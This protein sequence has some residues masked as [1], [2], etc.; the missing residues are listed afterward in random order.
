MILIG[1]SGHAFVVCGILKRAGR[2]ITGYCD[3]AEK[4]YNPF[5]LQYFGKENSETGLQAIKEHGYFIAVGDNQ[6]RRKIYEVLQKNNLSSVNA[7]HPSAVIDPSANIATEGVMVAANVTINPLA[8]I[9]TGAI[10]NTGCIIEHECIVGEFAHI[11]PGAVLCGNVKIGDGT[12][13][14]ANAVIRQGV[15]VGKNA[16]IGAG[17]VVIKDV[18][19][20]VTV[21]G[22][23]ARE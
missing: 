12:F 15:T 19:D 7:V 22:V 8:S 18:P 20:N 3:V 5:S 16:M 2:E 21:V 23:P 17:A 9:A 11:G 6:L 10:C 4:E 1:Y 14:G 13:V